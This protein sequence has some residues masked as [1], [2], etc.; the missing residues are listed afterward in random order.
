MTEQ[1]VTVERQAAIAVVTMTNP[2]QRNA[3]SPAMREALLGALDPLMADPETRALVL[4]GAGG[5]FCAG[6]DLKS[7]RPGEP[8]YARHRLMEGHRLVRLLA[9]GP[10]PVIAAVEG[11]AFGGGLSLAAIAD[12][13]VAARDA[14][15]GAA[16]GKVGLMPDLGMLWAVPARIGLGRAKRLAMLSEVLSGE[17][18]VAI[19]LADVAAE[20]G[21]ALGTALEQ[22]A[23]FAAAAPLAVAAT[24]AA[25]A[26]LPGPLDLVLA[27]E[28]GQQSALMQSADH[29]EAREAFLAK[30]TPEFRGK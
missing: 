22:A 21:Q 2:A 27:E 20:P 14:R 30:R 11:A 4:T 12:C 23:A 9:E 10:K 19:G 29:A 5:T 16:F 3:L 26:R 17:E 13:C 7:M 24:K 8:L 15:F 18:A 1:L 6:G 28:V 25:F